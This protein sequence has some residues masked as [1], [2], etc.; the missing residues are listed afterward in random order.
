MKKALSLLLVL[1][2][3]TCVM[4]GC[5]KNDVDSEA[6]VTKEENEAVETDSKTE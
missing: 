4:V 6:S 3:A 1:V 2:V 5:T